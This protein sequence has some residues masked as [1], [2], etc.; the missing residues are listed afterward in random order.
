MEEFISRP[1]KTISTKRLIVGSIIALFIIA[2]IVISVL[3]YES[4]TI[5]YLQEY[6]ISQAQFED[7]LIAYGKAYPDP[8]EYRIR[9]DNFRVNIAYISAENYKNK[10]WKLAVNKFADMSRKEFG[11]TY[12]GDNINPSSKTQE[13]PTSQLF[14][15]TVDWR[16]LNSVVTPVKDQGQYRAQWA[17]A[18]IGAIESAWKI[19]KYQSLALSEQQLID[20]SPA[21]GELIE[22]AFD[23]AKTA[24]LT[25]DQKYPYLGKKGQ[26]SY[27]DQETPAA[28]ISGYKYVTS[29][30]MNALASAVS[31][32]PVFAYVDGRRWSLYSS[33]VIDSSFCDKKLN[34][35][36][37]VV[38]FDLA[39]K[40][41]IVKNSWGADWGESGYVRVA[42]ENGDGVCG[43]QKQ[44][45][46]PVV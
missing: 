16:K 41:W 17:F 28:K 18:A 39:Q 9:F 40:F 3:T 37:L 36:V 45:L 29:N 34:H 15:S 13:K 6:E 43:L 5:K 30:N 35:A 31:T 24:G 1:R 22:N 2:G 44:A 46:Y 32:Q 26:C 25:T 11:D 42:I 33:G 7:Y 27:T 12:I 10:S 23:Y 38:G 4:K 19:Y 14:S 20:C 8:K 21:D